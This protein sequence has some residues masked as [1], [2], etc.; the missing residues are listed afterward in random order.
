MDIFSY[1]WEI[2]TVHI[3]KMWYTDWLTICITQPFSSLPDYNS[4]IS[5]ILLLSPSNHRNAPNSGFYLFRSWLGLG[6][7][8]IWPYGD[9]ISLCLVLSKWVTLAASG[10]WRSFVNNTWSM[11]EPTTW[12][13]RNFQNQQSLNNELPQITSD[14]WLLYPSSLSSHREGLLH[15]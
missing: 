10:H 8:G 5:L 3:C 6:P 1:C 9:I 4:Y 2:V 14:L 15:L 12:Y 7:F 11:N 13:N